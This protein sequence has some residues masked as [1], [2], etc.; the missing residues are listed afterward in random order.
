MLGITRISYRHAQIYTHTIS[1]FVPYIFTGTKT[2][3][4]HTILLFG[5]SK[6]IDHS[7]LFFIFKKLI[8]YQIFSRSVAHAQK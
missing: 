2:D 1:L 7:N 3:P 5:I 6:Q 8:L 4:Q